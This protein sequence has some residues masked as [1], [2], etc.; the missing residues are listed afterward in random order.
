MSST[1][2][3]H[4]QDWDGIAEDARDLPNAGSRR[5]LLGAAAG[6]FALAANGLF[7]PER[8]EGVDAREGALGA[9]R[10]GRRGKNHKGRHGHRHKKDRNTGSTDAPQSG[11]AAPQSGGG[12]FRSSAL[13]IYNGSDFALHCTFFYQ[14]TGD[15]DKYG[16]PI[17]NGEHPLAIGASHRYDPDRLR[18]GALIRFP[19]DLE[20]TDLYVDARN[21]PFPFYPRSGVTFGRHLD[22][23]NGNIGSTFIAEQN[24]AVGDVKM[25][26]YVMLGRLPDDYY[27]PNR[28]EW[29]VLIDAKQ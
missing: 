27:G 29:T 2:E 11:G 10:G 14:V 3:G 12:I 24:F 17:A 1:R 7:L 19:E 6:G 18:V 25:K 13:R 5:L 16:P 15:F 9:A 8:L 23:H 28:I 26:A 22:P 21:L 20:I 4:G